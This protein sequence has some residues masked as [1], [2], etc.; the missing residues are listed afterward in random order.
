MPRK[1]WILAVTT[2]CFFFLNGATFTSLGVV[3][4]TMAGELHW[5]QTAA[6]FS[7]TLLG[8]A[9]GLSSPLPAWLMKRYGGRL[10]MVLGGL[11]LAVGFTL[12]ATSHGLP[13]FYLA[14]V[15]L[16]TGYSLAGNVPGVFLVAAWFPSRAAR[17]IGFYLTGGAVGA[18]V[19]P[20]LVENVVTL[21]G[22]WRLHWVLMA[23]S[24]LVLAVICHLAIRD[25][26]LDN[27]EHGHEP[28]L[29]PEGARAGWTYRSAI[30]T[31][32][33]MLVALAQT[34]TMACVTTIHSV[35]VTHL[36]QL[37]STQGFAAWTLGVMA[38]VCTLA[39]AI[40]GPLSERVQ[41]RLLLGAG[42]LCQAIGCVIFAVAS[43]SMTVES[44]ALSFGLGWGLAYVAGSVALIDFFGRDIGS[45]VL[46][47]V[48][49]LTT[50]AAVGP[51]AAGAVADHFA[52]FSPIFYLYGVLLL[53]LAIPIALMHQPHP[54]TMKAAHA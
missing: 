12:A 31:P 4:F 16:G 15:L 10:T 34:M 53:A 35:A 6:G 18:V 20:P 42:L 13:L 51:L 24:A 48:W 39:K 41:P 28:S 11:T 25:V 36:T 21:S 19:G 27:R 8:L 32:Q 1:W 38:L 7:F 3:L 2:L 33:F 26:A 9:C 14:M 49:L 23:A 50:V 17:M 40:S 52:T 30:M 54:A 46:A 22:S 44:F 47:A 5:S 29:K 45:Q 43:N 37:G